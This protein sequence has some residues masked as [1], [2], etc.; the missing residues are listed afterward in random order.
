MA[1]TGWETSS[2][3]Y[4]IAPANPMVQSPFI[5]GVLDIRWD[6][7]TQLARNSPF[8]VVGVNIYRSE[9]SDRGPYFRVNE[10]PVQGTFYRDRTDYALIQEVVD[11][12]T[13]WIF[14][15]DAPNH[16]R[17][18]LK[19]KNTISKKYDSAAGDEPN[20]ASDPRDVLV[21]IDGQ[22]TDVDSVFGK[23][24]EVTL[25][26][27][28]SFDIATETQIN[29]PLF[30]EFSAVEI[31]YY[32]PKN[33]LNSGL[34]RYLHYRLTTVVT[35][36]TVPEG[37]RETPLAYATTVSNHEIEKLDYI[38]R[39]AVRRN[40]WILQQGGERVK[41]FVRKICGIPCDCGR[42]ARQ[43]DF[44]GQ[45]KNSCTICFGTG[46]VGG[47]DGPY[48]SIV[49]PDDSE[50]RMVQSARGRS[51][52]QTQEVWTGPSPI[53]TQRDFLVKQSN[54]RFSIGAVRR[55][56]NRGNILQQHFSMNHL[57]EG[58]IRYQVPIYG[59]TDL[60][61]PA[62]RDAHIPM[63]RIPID[64]GPSVE[65]QENWEDSTG[66]N[67]EGPFNITPMGTEKPEVPDSVEQRGRTRTW[68][69]QN[70]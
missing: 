40:G 36:S 28:P 24:G 54:E 30:N 58:D 22:Q 15:G 46:Y 34:D 56:S 8:N 64:G 69:D 38:W 49:C 31:H 52:S 11:W 59:T 29:K 5:R 20:W 67:P 62:T 57:D 3:D 10:Y 26:N 16:Y 63:P 37:V 61:Y 21:Y 42:P 35:D 66:P 33:Y 6:P 39:E 51:K 12:N 48:D 47:Y 14:K 7:P 9:G 50:R 68:E 43:I 1:L 44:D 13:S 4:P 17:W 45:H 23:T 55:P 27:E 19:T 41:I 60:A 32:T 25:V 65:K 2:T 18:Q 70:L 53:L